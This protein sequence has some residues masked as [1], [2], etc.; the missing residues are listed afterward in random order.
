MHNA[1]ELAIAIK[2]Y[3]KGQ[4][5]SQSRIADLSGLKQATISAF[6]KKPNATKL[7]TLF[8]I[9]AAVNLEILVQPKGKTA[10]QNEWKEEW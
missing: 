10:K 4:K 2:N 5:L 1:N 3:R 6:E 7:E 8:R 9:L